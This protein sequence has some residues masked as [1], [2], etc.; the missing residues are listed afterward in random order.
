M[1]TGL[2]TS[3]IESVFFKTKHA[4]RSNIHVSGTIASRNTRCCI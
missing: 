4:I 1:L 3:D 2:S